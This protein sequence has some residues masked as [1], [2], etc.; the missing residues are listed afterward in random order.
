MKTEAQRNRPISRNI[1]LGLPKFGSMYVYCPSV[2]M[3]SVPIHF[4]TLQVW[5]TNYIHLLY[6]ESGPIWFKLQHLER[7]P[8][9]VYGTKLHCL[10]FPSAHFSL[11]SFTSAFRIEYS[12]RKGG[13]FIRPGLLCLVH[14]TIHVNFQS[15]VESTVMGWGSMF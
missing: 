5:T 8:L 2:V 10:R 12:I 9:S 14:F 6:L 11:Q 13:D 4:E 7:E 15:S 1:H 3:K